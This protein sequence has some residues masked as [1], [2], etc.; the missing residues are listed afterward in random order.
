[1]P[2]F[3]AQALESVKST[4]VLAVQGRHLSFV[5]GWEWNSAHQTGKMEQESFTSDPLSFT[6]GQGEQ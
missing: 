4:K 1:M 3:L 2:R 6:Q 5:P